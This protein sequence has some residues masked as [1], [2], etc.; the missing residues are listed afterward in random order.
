MENQ[1]K[2]NIILVKLKYPTTSK[3]KVNNKS[4]P[5]ALLLLPMHTNTTDVGTRMHIFCVV[6]YLSP[7]LDHSILRVPLPM[8]M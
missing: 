3:D 4:F 6:L 8:Y 2:F 5:W 7:S 1:G